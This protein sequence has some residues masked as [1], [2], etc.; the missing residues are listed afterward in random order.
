MWRKILRMERDRKAET[1]PGFANGK[2]R[3][4]KIIPRKGIWGKVGK[5]GNTKLYLA[6]ED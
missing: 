5:P 6:W 4:G 3:G 1:F 2:S